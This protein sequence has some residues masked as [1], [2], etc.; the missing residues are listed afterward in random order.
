VL[1]RLMQQ[2]G[3]RVVGAEYALET[4]AVEFFDGV[5]DPG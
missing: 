2:D 4:G 3:L 5:A 1:E